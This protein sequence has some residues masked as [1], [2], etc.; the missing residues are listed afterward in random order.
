MKLLDDYFKLQKE[1]YDYF[2]YAEDWV[3]IPIED[4]REYYWCLERGN[5]P[6]VVHFAET[7]TE[8]QTQDGMYYINKIYFQCFLPKWVYRGK[9]HTMICV[10]THTDGNKFLQIFDNKKER[11]G[12]PWSASTALR[13]RCLPSAP[14][15][16]R[17]R[18]YEKHKI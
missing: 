1:I 17:R 15:L 9:D 13:V 7:E 18:I 12:I 8:L 2:G 5:Q 11:A 3:V 4:F 14:T 16:K 6:T 10:E